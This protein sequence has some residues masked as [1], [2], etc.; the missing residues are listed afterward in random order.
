MKKIIT[1]GTYT[2]EN[3]TFQVLSNG[4]KIV[5]APIGMHGN[6]L[7][8]IFTEWEKLRSDTIAI[9]NETR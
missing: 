1:V 8:K 7:K 6:T 4:K 9:V 3:I 5:H 2:I